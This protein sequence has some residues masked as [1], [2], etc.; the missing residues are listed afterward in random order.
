MLGILTFI[1]FL[2]SHKSF[3]RLSLFI[4]FFPDEESEVKESVTQ[5]V[6]G[7]S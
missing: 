3:V 1:V 5:M 7:E 4:P 2:D 6:S